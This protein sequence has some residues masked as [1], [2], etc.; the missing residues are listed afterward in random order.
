MKKIHDKAKTKTSSKSALQDVLKDALIANSANDITWPV[1]NR[2]Y[3]QRDD[4]IATRGGGEGLKLYDSIE[5]DPRAYAV[6]QKRRMA[7]IARPWA[8]EPAGD[9][10]TDRKVADFV[11]KAL[12]GVQFDRVCLNLLDATLKGFSVGEIV[13]T[14]R[15]GEIVPER[16]IPIDQRRIVFDENRCPRLLTTSAMTHGIALPERKFIVHR[17][18]DKDSNP[19]GL[20]LGAKLYWPVY[21]KRSGLQQWMVF[22]EKFGSPT[23][24][25]SYDPHTLPEEQQHRLH[26]A[27]RGVAQQASILVPEGSEISLLE[28]TRSAGGAGSYTDLCRYMDEQIAE[29]VLGETLT[30]NI[31]NAG[32]RAA[33]ETHN[34][35]RRELVDA[36]CDLLSDTLF[37]T[38]S[39]W[40]VAF[41]FPEGTQPP[42]I[43]RRPLETEDKLASLRSRNADTIKTL[44]DAGIVPDDATIQT[45][46]GNGWSRQ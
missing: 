11:H 3:T 25:A 30:T 41:N 46:L 22:L 6:L 33:S 12:Q 14:T 27:I 23:L 24:L 4:I 29:I 36:D 44:F 19:Q 38:L 26:Q 18:G 2:V 21:F 35:I 42:R 17:F 9:S 32:S 5:S 20:G 16:V 8:V 15:G 34:S 28:A 10:E 1:H 31:Q 7:V 13:W 45:M 40:L 43:I 39:A 37:E